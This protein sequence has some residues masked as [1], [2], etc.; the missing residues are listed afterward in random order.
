[1]P[2]SEEL[3]KFYRDYAKWVNEGAPPHDHFSTAT[4]LCASAGYDP[5]LGIEMR[6]QFA[7]AGFP[8]I[9]GWGFLPFNMDIGHYSR[10]AY[11]FTAHLNL[12]RLKWVRDHAAIS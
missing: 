4:G 5:Q 11:T 7:Q 8:Y 6:A 2:Q 1:M 10:E 12:K 9:K 3:T